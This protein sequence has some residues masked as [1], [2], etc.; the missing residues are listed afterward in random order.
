[1]CGSSELS[2]NHLSCKLP[3]F[4]DA[5]EKSEVPSEAKTILD[6]GPFGVLS[7]RIRGPNQLGVVLAANRRREAKE[8]K[9]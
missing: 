3:H 5:L 7:M 8:D 6:S 9:D 2:G 4:F 1:M